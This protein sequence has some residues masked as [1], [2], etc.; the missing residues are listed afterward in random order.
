MAAPV[1]PQTTS[2]VRGGHLPDHTEGYHPPDVPGS[3]EPDELVKGLDGKHHARKGT[4]YRNHQ[5][6][7][8]TYPL[9]LFK[10]VIPAPGLVE[11]PCERSESE[12]RKNTKGRKKVNGLSADPRE[13]FQDLS[14]LYSGT[15]L[16]ILLS[17][18][19][20]K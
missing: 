3:T 11:D 1:R 14:P 13:Q 19:S 10:E 2:P 12:G 20:T 4:G 6:R 18:P 17:R 5:D 9:K 16:I 8:D 7:S 15:T